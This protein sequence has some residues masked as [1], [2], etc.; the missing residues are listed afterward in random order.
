MHFVKP[1]PLIY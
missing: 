1:S